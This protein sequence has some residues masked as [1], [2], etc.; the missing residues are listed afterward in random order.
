M[1]TSA[2]RSKLASILKKEVAVCFAIAV[3]YQVAAT[4]LGYLFDHNMNPSTGLLDHMAKWD[5]GWYGAVIH[6]WYHSDQTSAAFY[7]LYPLTVWATSLFGLLNI[8]FAALIVNT[9][10]LW[11]VL[12]SFIKISRRLIGDKYAY[13]PAIFILISPAAFFMHV[14]YTEAL[15]LAI[16]L[17]SYL[18]ALHK[19]WLLMGILLGFITATR[20][21]GILFVALCFLEFFRAYDWK[22]KNLFNKNVLVFL[23]AP[24]G[25]MAYSA[26]LYFVQK[27]WLGMFHAY[28]YTNDWAYQQFNPNVI[29]TIL[30]AAYQVCR[31]VIGLR[32]FDNDIVVNHLLPLLALGAIVGSSVYFLFRVKKKFI[33]IGIFGLLAVVM[34]TLNNNL[35]S[36]H[37]YALPV[38]GIYLCVALL[39]GRSQKLKYFI[40]A[41]GIGSLLL[42]I[43]LFK[44]FVEV[45]FAG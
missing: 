16:G 43:F 38:F 7:P 32:P 42:Q 15:F 14:F 41:A 28:S 17:L 33:P 30:R 25:F 44:R 26:Y 27:D 4:L 24:L 40:A 19:R 6:D 37:R 22:V 35:V 18:A 23:F 1:T 29:E 10:S 21:P 34:F 11:V 39:W 31:A 13:L 20:L 8:T 36:V 2:L 5:G 45:I 3:A 9:A 12:F